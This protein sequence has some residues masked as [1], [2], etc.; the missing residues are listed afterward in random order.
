MPDAQAP[1]I[2]RKPVIVYKIKRR[3]V[4]RP[5]EATTQGTVRQP[6]DDSLSDQGPT[7][8][9]IASDL[10]ATKGNLE[11]ALQTTAG[12]DGQESHEPIRDVKIDSDSMV[13]LKDSDFSPGKDDLDLCDGEVSSVAHY[14]TNIGES[15]RRGLA[16]MMEVGR[17]CAEASERLTSSQKQELICHLPFGPTAFSKFVQIGKDTRLGKPDIQQLLSPH[18]TTTYCVSQLSDQ[19]LEHA[20]AAK[21]ISPEMT[22][23]DLEQ[24]LK[25]FRTPG[26][27]E[28]DAHQATASRLPARGRRARAASTDLITTSSSALAPESN[29]EFPACLDG[30]D[31]EAAFAALRTAWEAAEELNIA[32]ASAPSAVQARFVVEVLGITVTGTTSSTSQLDGAHEGGE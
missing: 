32:W 17:L 4:T 19:E 5:L 21:V 7:A 29:L 10:N 9:A 26:L 8:A 16:A 14:T 27:P 23:S 22:R 28:E 13:E 30:R 20:I 24:W 15:W 6:A 18:Y 3:A 25:R 12:Q 2:R 1:Q 11:P 31:P